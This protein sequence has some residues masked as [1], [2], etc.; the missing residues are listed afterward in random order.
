MATHGD[1]MH[2][3]NKRG[4]EGRD[5]CIEMHFDEA[6]KLYL[7]AWD[8][9]SYDEALAHPSLNGKDCKPFRLRRGLPH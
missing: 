1:A 5:A 3:L 2:W 8:Q 4:F 9:S 6:G 7:T